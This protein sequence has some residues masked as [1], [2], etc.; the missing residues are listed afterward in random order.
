M[1]FKSNAPTMDHPEGQYW[2]E[3]ALNF[4]PYVLVQ[5]RAS[6]S[7]LVG[8]ASIYTPKM[9]ERRSQKRKEVK[10]YSS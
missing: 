7:S 3:T 5:E 8:N 4:L 9:H 6:D 1:M 2:L 10:S